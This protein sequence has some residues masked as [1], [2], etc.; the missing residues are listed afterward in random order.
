MFILK[1][2]QAKIHCLF[3]IDLSINGLKQMAAR[4]KIDGFYEI[5]SMFIMH[6]VLLVL[7]GLQ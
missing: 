7:E 5:D 2:V 4:M 6:S 3:S 1:S